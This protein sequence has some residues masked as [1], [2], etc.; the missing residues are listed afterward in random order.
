MRIC[1]TRAL[2]SLT[3]ELTRRESILASRGV[4]P[5]VLSGAAPGHD[6]VRDGTGWARRALGHGHL[7]S[8]T[9][10]GTMLDAGLP[11]RDRGGRTRRARPR[12][13]RNHSSQRAEASS[14]GAGGAP[15]SRWGAARRGPPRCAFAI[16]RR[17]HARPRPLGRLGSGRLP[18]VHLPPINP[19]VFRGSYLFTSGETRL[20][21]GF[22]LRCFQRF[23]RPHVATQRCRLSDN[24]HTSGAST[25]VLSY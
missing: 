6:R 25:P 9:T 3:A 11:D 4:A 21:R 2:R 16:E 19:V 24:W 12:A 5:A 17:C 22:P 1:T 7:R 8:P 10:V 15:R 18:A 13:Y 14:F 23:A 20:G